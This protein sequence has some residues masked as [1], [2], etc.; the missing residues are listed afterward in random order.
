MCDISVDKNK[1]DEESRKIKNAAEYFE[2]QELSS[3][4]TV[5]TI[6]ANAAGQNAFAQSQN[7]TSRF[8][9]AL[10]EDAGHIHELGAKFEEF[11]QMME[12]LNKN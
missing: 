7:V 1:A 10:Q 5:S 6:T 4:D 8:G 9:T 2:G 11:D 12:K 3:K